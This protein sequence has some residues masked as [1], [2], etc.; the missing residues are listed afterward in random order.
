MGGRRKTK[1]PGP[2]SSGGPA[3]SA[4]VRGTVVWLVVSL[5]VLA[6]LPGMMSANY[7]PKTFWAA[8]AVGIGLALLPPRHPREFH[9]TPLGAVWLIYLSWA[10]LSLAWAPASRAG[11]ERWLAMLLPTLAYLLAKRTRFWESKFFWTA[12]C[13]L[14]GAV[15][16]IGILQYLFPAFPLIR[17]LPGTAVPRATLGSRNYASMYLMATFPFLLAYFFRRKWPAA[18]IPFLALVFSA[19]FLLLGKTRGA[20]VGLLAGMAWVAAAGG[21]RLIPRYKNKLLI[22]LLPFCLALLLAYSVGL[23]VGG[24][25]SF[26]GKLSFAQAVRTILNPRQRLQ[27]WRPVLGVTDPLLGAGFGNFPVAATPYS[28]EGKVNTLNWEVHNDYLQAYVDLGVPGALLFVLVFVLILRL[29]WKGRKNG[30]ILAAGAAAVGVAV[31]QFT[32]FT[33]EKVSTQIWFA[34]VAAL[35]NCAAEPR[36]VWRWRIPPTLSHGFNYLAVLWLLLFAAAAGYSIRGDRELRKASREIQKVLSFQEVLQNPDR[37]PPEVRE[38]VRREGPSE[39][40][41]ARDRLDR[42][43]DRV[44]PAMPF[45]ANMRHISSHQLAGLAWILDNHSAAEKFARRALE[46]HPADRTSLIYLTE[47]AIRRADHAR[48]RALLEEGLRIFGCNPHSPYFCQRLVQLY[49]NEGR[50]SE[51]A[52]LQKEM[53]RNLVTKPSSPSPGDRE[54]GVFPDSL[55]FDWSDCNAATCYDFFLWKVGEE[56]PE[57]PTRA[58][59]KESRIRWDKGL[60]PGTTYLWRVRAAGLYGEAR[61]DIWVFRTEPASRDWSPWN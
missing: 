18:A 49:R 43:A 4:S 20:W 39:L 3:G 19:T 52:A 24:E 60:T 56:E 45:D 6:C 28:A 23:P 8:L 26:R 55:L 1:R 13:A 27:F 16:A 22:L 44:L 41:R 50:L 48:I 14:V 36:P 12:F 61:G 46:L 11:F 10:L 25:S 59:L 30:W 29:A 15:S 47:I 5:V 54:S 58:G 17:N 42:L 31:M 38:Y 53:D 7:L 40:L 34:G 33:A 2:G 21:G 51:A 9:L 57:Y 35:L 32:T 37:Y